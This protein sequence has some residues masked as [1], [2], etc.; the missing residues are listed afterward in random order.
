[1][2]LTTYLTAGP[3]PQVEFSHGLLDLCNRSKRLDNTAL[4]NGAVLA[5]IDKLTQFGTKRFKVRQ[6]ALNLRQ[7]NAG[8]PVYLDAGLLPVVGKPQQLPD[9]IE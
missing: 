4:C 1:M 3:Y 5:L 9:L 7:V 6:L 2:R 8:Y